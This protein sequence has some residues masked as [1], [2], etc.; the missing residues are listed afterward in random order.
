MI[1]ERFNSYAPKNFELSLE[2]SEHTTGQWR[3]AVLVTGKFPGGRIHFLRF[4]PVYL[5]VRPKEQHFSGS[6]LGFNLPLRFDML[7][8]I[9]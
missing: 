3:I 8:S 6:S 9:V 1:D 2:D 7:L 5:K 4:G